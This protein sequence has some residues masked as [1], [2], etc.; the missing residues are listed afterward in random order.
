MC[1]SEKSAAPL[2]EPTTGWTAGGRTDGRERAGDG[3]K[4]FNSSLSGAFGPNRTRQNTEEPSAATRNPPLSATTD[5][6]SD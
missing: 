6:L 3:V 5:R 2:A 1:I 4:E